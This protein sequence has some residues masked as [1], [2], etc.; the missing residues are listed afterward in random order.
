LGAGAILLVGL[1]SSAAYVL[2]DTLARQAREGQI[3]TIVAGGDEWEI[4]LRDGSRARAHN[5]GGRP[6]A[7]VLAGFG[8]DAAQV[9]AIAIVQRPAGV[10]GNHFELIVPAIMLATVA[11]CLGV[12][13]R[14]RQ[15]RERQP[16]SQTSVPAGGALTT[17]R[18]RTAEDVKCP[19]S[20]AD[21]AG[22]EEAAEE[23]REVVAF[24]REPARFA[25]LGARVPRG[26][27]LSGPPGTGKTLLA[28]AVAGEAGVPF[29]STGGSEFVEVYVGVGAA[30]V[31]DLFRRA[32]A[33]APSIV[34]IDEIDT[35][36]R[37]RSSGPHAANE[38]REQALNQILVEMDGFIQDEPVIV[39]AATNR[40]DILDPALL[41]PGRFDRRVNV[42]PPDRAG[43]LAIL[44]IHLR[45]K[46][47]AADV[48]L[49]RLASLTS[50]FTGADLANLAN[51]AAILAARH[52]KAQLGR[53]ELEAAVDRV[54]AGP[55]RKGTPL[56]EAERRI[57]AYHE[58]GHALIAHRLD[59][60]SSVHKVTIVARGAAGGFTA[61]VPVEERR[62]LSR[63]QL[64]STLACALGGRAAEE[65]VFGESTSGSE[66][67]LQQATSLARRMVTSLG[68]SERVGPV[69]V[70]ALE[71]EGWGGA[72]A[73]ERVA[74]EVYAEVRRLVEEGYTWA[75]QAVEQ[76]RAALDRIA[77]ALLE[78]ETLSGEELAALCG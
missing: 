58:A 19:V 21:V 45:G 77:S 5:D 10:P 62:L 9:G 48:D 2:L 75:R 71:A 51:E 42:D 56:C 47:L 23:L 50:G 29:Y 67:D 30:R 26:V 15:E 76:E 53:L 55:E 41:R 1:P 52:G 70:G 34:F 68:M 38:E 73:G 3:A 60:R 40:T 66:N 8:L 49:K 74:R 61:L 14:R 20:F 25:A 18:F 64:L 54:V 72:S 12:G 78:R 59:P 31:R 27:L 39:I 36:G 13:A 57:V 4:I 37:R 11:G 7:T 17:A 28:R 43:R 6:V 16:G 69:A 46:P 35:I 65:A 24:L 32:K 44:G 33:T 22:V 63:S